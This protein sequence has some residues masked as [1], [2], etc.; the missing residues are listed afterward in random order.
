MIRVEGLSRSFGAIRAI[1]GVSFE[2]RDGRVTGLLGP[3]GAGKSTTLRVL[4]TVLHPDAGT[5]GVD[6]IDVVQDPL[7]ARRAIGVLPH[8]AGIYPQLTARENIA[9]FGALHGLAG[10]ALARRVDALI[11]E[12]DIVDCA[13]RRAKGFSQ[14]Q[15]IKVALARALVHQPRNLLLDEP[16]NGLDVMATRALRAL[17]LALRAAG[18]CVLFSSHVMQEVVALCDDIVIIDHGRVVAAGTPAQLLAHFQAATLED[19]F[20]A[21][22]GDAR[23]LE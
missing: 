7:T 1:D 14:G 18:H 4:Y 3:N 2:A 22:I 16:S 15:R 13:E 6:G 8:S 12:L 17:I 19:A 10:P 5:A 23:G 21:A 9:Y 11:A 20:V